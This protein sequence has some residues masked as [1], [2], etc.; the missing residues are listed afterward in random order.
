MVAAPFEYTGESVTSA[1]I[2]TTQQVSIDKIPGTYKLLIH[3]Y[4]LNHM[5][6]EAAEP[7]EVTLTADKKITGDL[8]GTWAITE[9]TSYMNMVIGGIAYRGVMV[10]QTLEM[11]DTKTIA[12]TGLAYKANG[13]DGVTVWAYQTEASSTGITDIEV[14]SKSTTSAYF[15]MSGRRINNPQRKG[16]YIRNGK[17]YI[18]K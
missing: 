14:N 6:K 15:D 7:V 10:E 17:K 1:D 12:F 5:T 4:K 16:L 3:K 18:V 8:T 2:A 9:G 13:T 11:K